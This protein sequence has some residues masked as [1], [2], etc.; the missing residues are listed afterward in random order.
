VGLPE[1]ITKEMNVLKNIK[2]ELKQT[3]W[4]TKAELVKTSMY[5]IVLCAIIALLLLVLDLFFHGTVNCFL[6]GFKSEIC[7]I[8]NFLN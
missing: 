7:P 4:P 1:L 6:E 3:T 5:T 2:K 8:S